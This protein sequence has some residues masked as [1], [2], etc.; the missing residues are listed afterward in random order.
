MFDWLKQRLNSGQTAFISH[1]ECMQHNVGEGHPEC[2]ERLMAIRD[3]LMAAQ[4]FDY[5]NETEAPLVTDEQLARVHAPRYIEYLEMSQPL[6]GTF[7]VDS[8]TAMSPATLR[9]ARRS[10]GA[11]IKA[12]DMVCEGKAPNA[13]CSIRPPGHHAESARAMGF[14]FF[15]NIAVGIRHAM[16]QHGVE[17][18]SIIDFDVHHGNGTEEIFRDDP[19]VQMLSIFQ[20]P[21]FPYCGDVPAGPNMVNVPLK[22]GSTGKEF[23]EV[24]LDTWLPKMRE[25][26]PQMLFISAGFDAHRE[27]DMGSLG[28]V[29]ADYE[30]V[31]RQLFDYADQHCGGRIVSVLEGGYDLS[32]LARSVAVHVKVLANG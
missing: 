17:R 24:V 22:A 3:Q 13:F 2:P 21:F 6:T 25:F 20:H 10:A 16:A 26:D 19:K 27:D 30:W 29:E 18:V 23:R 4:I 5:L 7:R 32:A 15:N 11:V 14:C 8:D 12:V 28:L 9:A 1:N 31:T